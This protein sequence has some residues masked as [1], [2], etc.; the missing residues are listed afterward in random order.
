MKNLYKKGLE[1][2]KYKNTARVPKNTQKPAYEP[3][4][5]TLHQQQTKITIL[6]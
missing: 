6:G 2:Q 1:T 4:K 3:K 5:S